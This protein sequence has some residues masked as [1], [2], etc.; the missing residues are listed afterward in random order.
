MVRS[1]PAR[2]GGWEPD[3][4]IERDWVHPS[5]QTHTVSLPKHVADVLRRLTLNISPGE[6]LAT[7]WKTHVKNE[8][9]NS[10]FHTAMKSI[11]P[12]LYSTML[13][14]SLLQRAFAN[15]GDETFARLQVASP[16][17]G[18]PA[19]CAYAN[20]SGNAVASL[21]QNYVLGDTAEVIV[22]GSRLDPIER[23]LAESIQQAGTV[24]ENHRYGTDP[25]SFHNAYAAYFC[26]SFLAVTGAR[27]NNDPCES[28]AHIN[29]ERLLCYIDDKASG[30]SP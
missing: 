29:R 12:R 7:V 23:V 15:S 16:D 18:M 21:I 30:P 14:N 3:S 25:L 4:Q 13:P 19:A 22:L 26:V 28:V 24:V 20:W 6:L 9:W 17:T 10:D 1:P 11:A 27:P 8:S 2:I 5:S